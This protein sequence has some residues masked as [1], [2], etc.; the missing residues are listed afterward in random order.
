MPPNSGQFQNMYISSFIELKD[1][2]VRSCKI[3]QEWDTSIPRLKFNLKTFDPLLVHL[4]GFF[5]EKIK[6]HLKFESLIEPEPEDIELK[7]PLEDEASMMIYKAMS[8]LNVSLAFSNNLPEVQS[9]DYNSGP[10]SGFFSLEETV[11]PYVFKRFVKED[12]IIINVHQLLHSGYGVRFLYLL[13]DESVMFATKISDAGVPERSFFEYIPDRRINAIDVKIRYE[14]GDN[15]MIQDRMT[16]INNYEGRIELKRF[17]ID[18]IEKVQ[19]PLR[20][21]HSDTDLEVLDQCDLEISVLLSYVKRTSLRD[22]QDEVSEDEKFMHIENYWG[23]TKKWHLPNYVEQT[24][25]IP[26]SEYDALKDNYEATMGTEKE[27]NYCFA[28]FD[29]YVELKYDLIP[30]CRSL[31]LSLF[32]SNASIADKLNMLWDTLIFF[33]NLT[34]EFYLSDNCLESDSIQYFMKV[35]CSGSYVSIPEYQADNLVDYFF[36]GK[37]PNIRRA[38][39]YSAT[40]ASPYLEII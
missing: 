24:S 18:V 19:I 30:L 8:I 20:S 2:F 38:F 36:Y 39:Y 16:K 34:E 4:K 14:S 9:Y 37:V 29:K 31:L 13:V 7:N 28:V 6:N 26:V 23:S 11:A 3:V 10:F 12:T 17:R 40:V 21:F 22:F 32:Y 33:E 1:K 15:H 5:T 27:N 25:L 35:I